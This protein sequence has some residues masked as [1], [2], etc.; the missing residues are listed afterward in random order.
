MTSSPREVDGSSSI[1][2][3]LRFA[4]PAPTFDVEGDDKITVGDND[5]DAIE[6]GD[7]GWSS[8]RANWGGGGSGAATVLASPSMAATGGGGGGVRI[9]ISSGLTPWFI[10]AWMS[11]GD[12]GII[13]W[14]HAWH[15]GVAGLF[16]RQYWSSVL[17]LLSSWNE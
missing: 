16:E 10:N 2:E 4:P 8:N 5:D 3:A 17:H 15:T 13:T 1:V 7:N 14:P 11:S 12:T 6:I 9:T